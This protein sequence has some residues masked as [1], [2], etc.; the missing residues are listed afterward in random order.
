[1]KERVMMN[2]WKRVCHL[3]EIPRPGA[4]VVESG[5]DRIALF[6]TGEDEVFALLDRCPHRG[7][8]LSEGIVC[9]SRVTCPMHGLTVELTTGKAAAPDEGAVRTFPVMIADGLV[10]LQV[11]E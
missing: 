7:G 5:I 9:G 8:P 3:E 10:F 11:E 1:M 2:S 4:R 6:R